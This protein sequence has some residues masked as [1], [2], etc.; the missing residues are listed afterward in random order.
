MNNF[1]EEMEKLKEYEKKA[2]EQAFA[3][4]EA[5]L[6]RVRNHYNILKGFLKVM[7]PGTKVWTRTNKDMSYERDHDLE[8][9]C[10]GENPHLFG[11]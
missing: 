1:S 9:I 7:G 3:E 8:K 4:T 11:D 2:I 6:Q 5:C 10:N